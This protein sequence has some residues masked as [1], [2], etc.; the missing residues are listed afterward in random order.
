MKRTLNTKLTPLD[1]Q[2]VSYRY[3]AGLTNR[4]TADQL[5]L[6]FWQV[7]YRIRKPQVQDYIRRRIIPKLVK[8]MLLD[9]DR[10]L[11]NPMKAFAAYIQQQAETKTFA[12]GNKKRNWYDHNGRQLK[13]L[14]RISSVLGLLSKR[15]NHN[16]D[17]HRWVKRMVSELEQKRRRIVATYQ[18][19]ILDARAYL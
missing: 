1:R 2:I 14:E 16:R 15:Q 19:G 18:A 13:A 6:R 9:I 5:K 12:W 11:S 4:E 10:K 7:K 8:A 3:L 17:I